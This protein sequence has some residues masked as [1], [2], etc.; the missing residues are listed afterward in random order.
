MNKCI[1]CRN[2][3]MVSG[4]TTV[5]LNKG[6]HIFLFKQVPADICDTCGDY[7][8]SMDVADALLKQANNAEN[9]GAELEIQQYQRAG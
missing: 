1:T 4:Y 2:G 7:T 3:D 8:L 6:D 9:R 5:T